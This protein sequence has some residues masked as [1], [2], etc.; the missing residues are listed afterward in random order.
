MGRKFNISSSDGCPPTR[1]IY[2]RNPDT[3]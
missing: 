3:I 2:P 1:E